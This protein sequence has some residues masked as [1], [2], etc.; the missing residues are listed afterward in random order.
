MKKIL[1]IIALTLMLPNM[2]H[3]EVIQRNILAVL[4]SSEIKEEYDDLIHQFA[5]MPL[6][7]LGYKLDYVDV[8]KRLPDEA[9]MR[10]YHGII[11][12]FTDNKIRGAENYARWLTRQL[13]NGKKLV[14]LDEPGFDFDDQQKATSRDVVEDFYTAFNA[15][16]TPYGFTSSPFAIEVVHNDPAMTEFERPLGTEITSFRELTAADRSAKIFLKLKRRDTGKLCDA[17]FAHS[18]GGI[19]LPGYVWYQNPVNFQTRWRLNP[20]KFFAYAFDSNFPKPDVSTIN[21]MRLMYSHIDGDGIRNLSEMDSEPCPEVLYDKVLTQYKLPIAVSV[22][23]GDILKTVGMSRKRLIA[24]IKKIFDLPNVQT[25]SHGWTHPFVWKKKG[26]KLAFKLKGF[27]YSPAAEIEGSIDYINEHLAPTGKK[28]HTFFWTGDCR[29][30]YEALKYTYDHGILNLNGGDTRFDNEYP[31][32]MYVAPLFRHVGGLL[33]FFTANSN[34]NIY[35]RL[36]KGPFYGY[37]FVIETFKRTESP[38]RIRPIDVYYH[39]YLLEK[40]VG[41][42]SLVDTYNWILKQEIT[43]V[44]TNHYIHVMQ[45]FLSTEIEKLSDNRWVVA[46]NGT[47]STIRFDDEKRYVNLSQSKGV[48][49]FIHYQSSLYVHLDNGERSE[50]VLTNVPPHAPYIAKAN[51]VVSNWR[52][53]EDGA[54]FT[55]HTIGRV[56]FSI[57]ALKNNSSYRVTANKT[58]YKAKSDDQGVLNFYIELPSRS[59]QDIEITIQ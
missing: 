9:E 11:S 17:V 42:E 37:R 8:A 25:A 58:A 3:A 32:Y 5:E 38:I 53:T 20:F 46:K 49:G 27:T 45:G 7:H 24:S 56:Q 13:A 16:Y 12:W 31:S 54:V 43:P 52:G 22:V 6:N 29:P 14:I 33:Q 35:T 41:Y 2:A 44:F 10:K 50:I 57:A 21:G 47:L 51:G 26:R 34:E 40:V 19:A 1:L 48:L 55:L 28:T 30:D 15:N 59:Y 18:K 4:D 36:W 23:I 39:F